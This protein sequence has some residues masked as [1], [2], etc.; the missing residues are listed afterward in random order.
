MGQFL[1]QNDNAPSDP[2]PGAVQAVHRDNDPRNAM[3]SWRK[4]PGVV[5]YNILWGIDQKKLYETY[6]IFAD[7]ES[8]KEIRALTAGQD[9]YFTIEAF[10]EKGVSKQSKVIHIQ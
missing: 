9:Y 6:Q 3:V 2:L 10:N 1:R 5:G 7:Q 4:V 8:K